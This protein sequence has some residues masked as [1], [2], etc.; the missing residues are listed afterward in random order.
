MKKYILSFLLLI[1]FSGFAQNTINNYKYVIVPEK[2]SFLKQK[3]QYRLNTLLKI[4]LQE[5]GFTSYFDNS[6]LPA[7]LAGN[8]CNALNADVLEKN[9]MFTTNVTVVLKDCKGNILFTSK[10]G[11]SR[12]KE[13]NTSYNLALRDALSSFNEIQYAY[14]GPATVQTAAAST[15]S[16]IPAGPAVS[17][18]MATTAS[19][20]AKVA[21]PELKQPEGT[22]YAQPTTK[23][24][25][26]IDTTP[27]IIL[28]L[29]TTS[30]QDY[31][32]AENSNS[33]GI[34]FKKN[35][36]WFYEYYQNG[37]LIAEKL[38]IKF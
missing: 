35:G 32:I 28:T 9:G 26:L 20:P 10:E 34:V 31:F 30:S 22:L 25:Q 7:E 29:L 4:F 23:G 8:R 37:N 12:E 19:V 36:T 13:Y 15:T 18:P 1:S 16:T 5:K 6:E 14:S 17:T 21:T 2:F 3:D 11:K 38:S 33:H 27:K 24:Y